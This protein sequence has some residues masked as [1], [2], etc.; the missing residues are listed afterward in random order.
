MKPLC[1]PYENHEREENEMDDTSSQQVGKMSRIILRF[2]I[3]MAVYVIYQVYLVEFAW[4]VA[5]ALKEMAYPHLPLMLD[6]KVFAAL[7]LFLSISLFWKEWRFKRR[8]LLCA[9]LNLYGGVCLVVLIQ[10]IHHFMLMP[11]ST[12][13]SYI[14]RS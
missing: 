1:S 2:D 6:G 14:I 10:L 3:L 13:C 8:P 12:V 9:H 7:T 4:Q 11:L 5:P